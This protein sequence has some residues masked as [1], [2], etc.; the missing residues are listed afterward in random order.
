MKKISICFIL[1]FSNAC[2]IDT[3]IKSA[4]LLVN[5]VHEPEIKEQVYTNTEPS[6][7]GYKNG[8]KSNSSMSVDYTKIK[9]LFE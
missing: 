9:S 5:E 7:Q 1:L 6:L 3:S 4:T 8:K 2:M